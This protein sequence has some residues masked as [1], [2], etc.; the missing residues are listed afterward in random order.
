MKNIEKE[1]AQQDQLIDTMQEQLKAF[2]QQLCVLDVR[3]A[4]RA[5]GPSRGESA[6]RVA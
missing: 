5:R 2:H 3:S 4:R 6:H 1:K